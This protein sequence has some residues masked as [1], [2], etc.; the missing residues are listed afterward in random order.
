MPD[1][2]TK[3]VTTHRGFSCWKQNLDL[4]A[5]GG[6]CFSC[7]GETR[8]KL[9]NLQLVPIDSPNLPVSSQPAK[10]PAHLHVQVVDD[11]QGPITRKDYDLVMAPAG[12]DLFGQVVDF[13]GRPV[14]MSGTQEKSAASADHTQSSTE[15]KASTSSSNEAAA[16]TETASTASVGSSLAVAEG[17][18]VIPGLLSARQALGSARSRP[19]LNTQVA[20]K[21]RDQICES[22]FTGVKVRS[23]CAELH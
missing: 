17:D 18:D 7:F 9:Q 15:S 4:G 16:V 13:L 12:D 5:Y 3:Q 19:L 20:M 1:K 22:M 23:V 2:S 21:D 8:H 14:D 10:K 6:R 11:S